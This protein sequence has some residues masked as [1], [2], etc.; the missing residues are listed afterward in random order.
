MLFLRIQNDQLT[1]VQ[2]EILR[3]LIQARSGDQIFYG[4]AEKLDNYLS[5]FIA[6]VNI[7]NFKL[8]K[9]L[10]GYLT[11]DVDYEADI[12][13]AIF[14]ILKASGVTDL[15]ELNKQEAVFING[16]AD[17]SEIAI[18]ANSRTY[19]RLVAFFPQ[20]SHDNFILIGNHEPTNNFGHVNVNVGNVNR[21]DVRGICG[22]Q[23][24]MLDLHGTDLRLAWSNFGHV[25][26]ESAQVNFT[27]VFPHATVVHGLKLSYRYASKAS[28]FKALRNYTKG[29]G[30]GLTTNGLY[31]PITTNLLEYFFDQTSS[32]CCNEI[33]QH[34]YLDI[35]NGGFTEF[36]KSSVENQ[37]LIHIAFTNV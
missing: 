19:N 7:M 21:I 13:V 6:E 14:G 9:L 18:R 4:R 24:L 5:H 16:K 17:I 8:S 15:K 28:Y 37:L 33:W 22:N 29:E 23:T 11:A 2:D 30:G 31:K 32:C 26:A 36:L 27:S 20:I 10:V 3:K 35:L 1:V 34:N 12:P 25:F